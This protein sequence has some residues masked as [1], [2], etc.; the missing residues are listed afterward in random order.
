MLHSRGWLGVLAAWSTHPLFMWLRLLVVGQL[1]SQGV[2]PRRAKG[3]CILVCSIGR[4]HQ[5][6]PGQRG[7]GGGGVD[8]SSFNFYLFIFGCAKC[9]MDFYLQ[10]VGATL[11]EV[12]GLLTAVASLVAEHGLWGTWALVIVIPG[13]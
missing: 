2:C 8:P 13:L 7:L 11:V 10:P 1:G 12:R 5:G 3:G 6:Q 4:S 9:C